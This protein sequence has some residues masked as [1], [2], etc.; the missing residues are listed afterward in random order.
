[1]NDADK[2]KRS[3]DKL[4]N[5]QTLRTNLLLASL[6]LTAYELLRETITD[7]IRRFFTF[8][9]MGD[10]ELSIVDEQYQEVKNWTKTC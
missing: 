6:Y 1:M 8:E 9:F 3:W 5:T 7:R 2:A 10:E 4:L